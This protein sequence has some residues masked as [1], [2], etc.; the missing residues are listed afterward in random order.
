[1]IFPS[2]GTI[3]STEDIPIISIA[4]SGCPFPPAN[5][6]ADIKLDFGSNAPHFNWHLEH[7][8]SETGMDLELP[9]SLPDGEYRG[10]ARISSPYS[11]TAPVH[12]FRATLSSPTLEIVF[13]IPGFI[14]G[15]R[16]V[17]WLQVLVSDPGHAARG[18]RQVN[19]LL[20]VRVEGE[21]IGR[22]RD[23]NGR[24]IHLP[25]GVGDRRVDLEVLDAA[26]RRTG[27]NA[28]LVVAVADADED[29]LAGPP[30]AAGRGFE[31]ACGETEEVCHGDGDCSGHGVCRFGRRARD[32]AHGT[33]S[34][35]RAADYTA[36]LTHC[37]HLTETQ[38]T[39]RTPTTCS[40][41]W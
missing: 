3:F 2:D 36:R 15:R 41:K 10:H 1:M 17:P 12:F 39:K 5:V 37:S 25:P 38:P 16:S 21:S 18:L 23:T 28:S 31:P 22:M 6:A 40:G 24:R 7:G 33:A 35:C 20:D 26:G 34:V 9:N 30:R 11:L 19:H 4:V 27:A 13:P 29:R 14:F 8:L 32:D